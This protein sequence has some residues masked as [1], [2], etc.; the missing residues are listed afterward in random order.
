MSYD[1]EVLKVISNG[2]ARHLLGNELESTD[3]LT[4]QTQKPN[5]ISHVTE[6]FVIYNHLI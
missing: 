3:L 6:F 2:A 4:E 1:W 5:F